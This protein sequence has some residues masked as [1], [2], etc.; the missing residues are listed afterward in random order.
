VFLLPAWQ[1]GAQLGVAQMFFLFLIALGV[2]SQCFVVDE[3]TRPSELPQ[4][5]GFLAIGHQ[6]ELEALPSQ[7]NWIIL[8]VY[9]IVK[10]Y[11]SW[12]ALRVRIT[13]PLGLRYEISKKG[14]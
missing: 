13:C 12:Q 14:V 6:L 4:L 10:G 5:A 1:Q 3:A 7:H 9:A 8:L 11:P 2:E